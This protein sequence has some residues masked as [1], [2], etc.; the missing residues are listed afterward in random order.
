MQ[1]NNKEQQEM[2]QQLR[3][4]NEAFPGDHHCKYGV[5]IQ[6]FEGCIFFIIREDVIDD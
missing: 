6:Y 1:T 3:K 2:K 5:I 4:C